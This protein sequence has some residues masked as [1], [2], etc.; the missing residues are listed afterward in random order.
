VRGL[1][2]AAA[3]GRAADRGQQRV[4]VNRLLQEVH[5]SALQGLDTGR[6][7]A[8]TGDEHQRQMGRRFGEFVLELESVEAG[9]PGSVT[10]QYTS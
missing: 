9:H 7:I 3:L 6:D 5:S 2:P 4:A 8:V 1:Q 10:T